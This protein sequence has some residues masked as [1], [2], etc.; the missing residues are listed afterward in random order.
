MRLNSCLH[1]LLLLSTRF[2]FPRYCKMYFSDIV[3]CIYP[4]HPVRIS[5]HQHHHH[6]R[7]L[8]RYHHHHHHCHH[9]RHHLYHCDHDGCRRHLQTDQV[10]GR[11]PTWSPCLLPSEMYHHH[12]HHFHHHQQLRYHYDFP[13]NPCPFLVPLFIVILSSKM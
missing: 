4:V 8:H 6:H 11:Q 12:N 1:L 13:H 9:H 3:M 2:V 7:H 5:H 10:M